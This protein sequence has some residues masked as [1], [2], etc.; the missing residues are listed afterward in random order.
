MSAGESA[1]AERVER[2]RKE[3]EEGLG[4]AGKGRSVKRAEEEWLEDIW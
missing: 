2:E 4:C 1:L 3:E